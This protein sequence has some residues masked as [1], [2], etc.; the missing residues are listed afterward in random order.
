MVACILGVYRVPFWHHKWSKPHK[1]KCYDMRDIEQ[2]LKVVGDIARERGVSMAAVA[3][4]YTIG[5]GAVPTVGMR[6]PD[7]ARQAAEALG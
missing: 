5:K 7:D 2:T 6:H 1:S 3:L 4:N